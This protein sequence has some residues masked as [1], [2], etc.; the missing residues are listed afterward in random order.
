VLRSAHPARFLVVFVLGLFAA[1]GPVGEYTAR[2]AEVRPPTPTLI[3]MAVERGELDRPTADR[4]L[5]AALRGQEVP[6][7]YSSQ[8]PYRATLP[9]FELH[10]RLDGMAAGP[11]RRALRELLHPTAGVGMDQCDVSSA[12]MPNTLE[13]THFYIEYNVATLGGGLTIEDYVA[14]LEESWSKEVDQFGWAAPPPYPPNP[15]PN[16]KYH[17]RIDTLGLTIYGFVATSGTHA[18]FVGNNP[19]TSW[20]EGDAFASCMVLNANYDPFPGTPLAALQST[21]AHEF[22]HSIQFGWGALSGSNRPDY[23]FFEGGATWMEDEVFD[24]SN[25]NYNYL[26]PAFDDDMGHYKDNLPLQPYA[27]WVTWRGLTEPYGT[28]IAGGGE[29]VMQ[30]FWE[31]TSKNQGGSLE[32][33]DRSLGA[34]GTSLGT[35]FH[36]YAIAVKFNK[37]CGSGYASPHCLEE[38]PGYVAAKGPTPTNGSVAMNATFSGSIFDNYAINWLVLPGSTDLQAILKNTSGGGRFRATLACDTGSG[39]VLAPFTNVVEGGEV[40]YVRDW[41]AAVC[42]APIAVITNVTQTAANPGSSSPRSYTLQV[43]PPAMPTTLTIKGRVSRSHVN[44]S[45]K[46]TPPGGR[47]EVTLF[48]REGGWQEVKSR[49]VSAGGRF[50]TRFPLPDAKKCRLEAEFAGTTQLLPSTA[51]KTFPC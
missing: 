22:N 45:G 26:W 23:N 34:E 49:K 32:A 16:N 1:S 14:A 2:A 29:D 46:L 21:A 37:A 20:N 33:L 28:G 8:T 47:V 38:G 13:T 39:L 4:Y 11:E 3:E 10:R 41:D 35:A 17:V 6:P 15:A 42:P 36:S 30:R 5:V 44:A 9:L 27:Y 25:D 19:A 24:S 31:T 50:R 18:G 12:P 48:E 7:A 51:K 43:T 40:A